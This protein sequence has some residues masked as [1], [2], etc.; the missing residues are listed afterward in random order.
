[1]T[2]IQI[3][4][5]KGH[6]YIDALIILCII[7]VAVS[8]IVDSQY[9]DPAFSSLVFQWYGLGAVYAAAAWVGD[10]SAQTGRAHFLAPSILIVGS[11]I[12]GFHAQML[13]PLSAS[14]FPAAWYHWMVLGLCFLG[15]ACCRMNMSK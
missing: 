3:V 15:R 13:M 12:C 10:A 14:A 5:E 6:R 8:S 7:H 4:R 9:G 11:C 2:F 1:M